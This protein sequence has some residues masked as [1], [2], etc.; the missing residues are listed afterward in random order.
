MTRITAL[1]EYAIYYCLIIIPFVLAIAPAPTNV[2]MGFL[3]AAFLAKKVIG[4]KPLARKSAVT[5]PLFLFFLA[6]CLS[7]V[8]S[9][10]YYDSI[11]GGVLRLLQYILVFFACAEHVRDARHARWIFYSMAL[12]ISLASANAFWQVATGSD[13]IRGYAPVVNL[14]LVRATASF[15]DANLLGIYLSAFLP[16]LLGLALYLARGKQRLIFAVA[17]IAGLAGVFLTYSRPT[18][19]AVY[20]SVFLLAAIRRSRVILVLLLLAALALPI[21]APQSIKDWARQMEYNPL[22]MMCNDDRIAVYRNSLN[23]IR[24]HPVT[25]VGANTFMEN[26]RHY[27]ENPEYRNIVTID[28]MYAHN[29]F[30]HMAGEVGLIG[31]G[32]FI[33]FLAALFRQA[34]RTLRTLKDAQARMLLLGGVACLVAFLVNGLTES[35]LYYS[36]VAVIFWYLA[37]ITLAAANFGGAKYAEN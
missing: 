35:S 36:R 31:F 33:W 34:L 25:G 17:S 6:T 30:L 18:Y 19:L 11:K 10:D 7:L 5:I 22:R 8:N 24:A 3:I 37:G 23:M 4:K 26:Y 1:C 2:F 15:K 29:N 12:G 13:F 20:V 27:K 9:V 32:L 21:L 28:Y 14:G 16:L